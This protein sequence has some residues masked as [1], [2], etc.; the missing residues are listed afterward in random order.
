MTF[1]FN[2][3]IRGF[4]LQIQANYGGS[5][6]AELEACDASNVS[7]GSVTLAGNSTNAGD[8]GAIFIG[9]LSSAI[10]IRAV[11]VKAPIASMSPDDFAINGPRIQTGA[12]A[13]PEP[14]S[15]ALAGA[16]LLG[17]ACLRRKSGKRQASS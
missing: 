14:A 3:L 1:F 10:D 5:F 12:D 7:L 15:I 4:G 6:T 13:V 17:L 9:V 11:L 2:S 16:A 8:D